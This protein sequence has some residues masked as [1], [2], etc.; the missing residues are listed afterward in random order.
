MSTRPKCEPCRAGSEPIPDE[1]ARLPIAA[2]EL[3]GEMAGRK[4][5]VA[6]QSE[7]RDDFGANRFGDRTARAEAAARRRIDGARRFAG[8]R[9]PLAHAFGPR[10]G[11]RYR[12]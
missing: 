1:R 3:S 4:V 12:R 9:E 6:L 11:D 7:R 10:V 8:E 5:A 2:S